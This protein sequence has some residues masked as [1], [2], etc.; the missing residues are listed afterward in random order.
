MCLREKRM[1][2]NLHKE[3]VF[4][5]KIIIIFVAGS[6]FANLSAFVALMK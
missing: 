3:T 2:R 4:L 5:Q 1:E 6:K